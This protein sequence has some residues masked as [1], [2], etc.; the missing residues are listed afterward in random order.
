MERRSFLAVMGLTSTG[1]LGWLLQGCSEAT[2]PNRLGTETP[3]GGGA[4]TGPKPTPTPTEADEYVPGGPTGPTPV[5]EAPTLP[6]PAWD[7]RAKQLEAGAIYTEAAP[8]PWK[9]RIASHLPTMVADTVLANRVTVLVNHVM[10]KASTI[11]VDGGPAAVDAGSAMDAGM[12]AGTLGDGA[13]DDA[14]DGGATD[15]GTPV[16][17]AAPPPPPPPTG[18]ISV[19]EH[20]VTTIYV[21][22]DTG[23]VAGLLELKVGDAAPPSVTFVLPA[24]TK[25]VTAYEFCNL[26]G[27]WASKPLTLK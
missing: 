7:A 19:P 1:G 16:I 17:D 5:V 22:T 15:G 21:K 6:N 25:S 9:D 3:T 24:G 18:P 26:H 20:Y 11:V 4:T 23:V 13:V 8:G 10:Q 12:D 27:L 2:Q 14:G